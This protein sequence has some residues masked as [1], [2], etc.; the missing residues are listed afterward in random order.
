MKF[1]GP[2][3]VR[4]IQ[5]NITGLHDRKVHSNAL[6]VFTALFGHKLY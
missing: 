6:I 5:H 1:V 3:D 2:E 4:V